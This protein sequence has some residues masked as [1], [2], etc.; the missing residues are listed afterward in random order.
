LQKRWIMPE[1]VVVPA[2][3]R[4]FVG[5]HSVVAETLVRRGITTI[6]AARVFLDPE[7]YSPAPP[8]D[9]PGMHAAVERLVRAIRHQERICVWGDFDVDG[10]T[11]TTILVTTLRDLGADIVYHIPVRATE[12][13]GMKVPWLQKELDKGARLILT[14]DTGIDAHTAIDYASARGVDVIITDHHELPQTLP[15]ACAIVNPHLLADTHP[16]HTL[17]GVGVAYKLAEALYDWAGRPADVQQYLDLVALGIVADVA[18]QTGDA[19]YLLQKGLQA[20]RNTQRLGLREL[21]RWGNISSAHL[22]EDDIGFGLAPRLN[23]LG[24]LDDANVIVEFFTT[25]DLGR[26]RILSS[27]LEALN[28]RRKMLCEQ[29]FAAAQSQIEQNPDLLEDAAL[30][31]TNPTWSPGVIGIVANRL[32]DRYQRP[33]VLLTTPPDDLAH[34]SARSIAGCH[35]TEAIAAQ[36]DLLSGFGGHQMAAGLALPA[37]NIPAFRK[38][39]SKVVREHVGTLAAPTLYI[40]GQIAFA[41]VSFELLQDINRLG[42]FG[43]G[44]PALHL[45]TNS[46]KVINKRTLGRDAK[47]L[48]L[49][50]EDSAGTSQQVVWWQWN[51]TILPEAEFDLVYSLHLNTFRGTARLQLVYEA[52]RDVVIVEP[53][54]LPGRVLQVIDYRQE[55]HPMTLLKPLLAQSD[56]QVWQEAVLTDEKIGEPR[57]ELTQSSNLIIWT[58]PPGPDELQVAIRRV[59]PE[60]IYLFCVTSNLD[61]VPAFLKYL[62]GLIKYA[63]RVHDGNI[64]I[65]QLAAQLGQREAIVR[66]AVTWLV[67]QG[68]V[69]ICTEHDDALRL[70]PDI[71]HPLTSENKPLIRQLQL[72]LGET[73]AYRK[74]FKQMALDDLEQSLSSAL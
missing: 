51:G 17:P 20:L 55:P 24:R 22:S 70:Q 19:R 15:S 35:I 16:L 53:T 54:L 10:Q 60:N 25:A 48:L 45:F 41:D 7:A 9:F 27:Q 47:H 42:P 3:L 67:A 38:R 64:H 6:D 58:T 1:S 37:E 49:T 29:V 31:L 30:V 23:A 66:L 73:V 69:R 8:S 72:S 4:D 52:I 40:D 44:N 14:C 18:V 50:V 63:L 71:V 32:V 57:H 61:T 33:V 62:T 12:S 39:L 56:V 5:G 26:A 46:V 74:Y 43:A 28:A 13:H 59:Q 68:Y 21:M 2:D 36:S 34:G 65:S 11:S